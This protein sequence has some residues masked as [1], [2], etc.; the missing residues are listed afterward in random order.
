M[1]DPGYLIVKFGS[2][3][4]EWSSHLPARSKKARLV[5]AGQ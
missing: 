4:R 3:K 5:S 2:V 1:P